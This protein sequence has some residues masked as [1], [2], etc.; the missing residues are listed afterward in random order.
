[1]GNKGKATTTSSVSSMEM[2]LSVGI[3][4]EIADS[5][6]FTVPRARRACVSNERIPGVISLNSFLFIFRNF[7]TAEELLD[8]LIE[9]FEIPDPRFSDA[10]SRPLRSV[11][12]SYAVRVL[13]KFRTAN[14]R[15]MQFRVVNF[16]SKWIN[17]AHYFK[18][19]FASK[20]LELAQQ[21]TMFEWRMYRV[22]SSPTMTL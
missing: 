11:D 12:S 14:K 21:I 18:M 2:G 16:V 10:E 22:P 15:K 3:S 13:K 19:D 1:M 4:Y 17:D 6:Y 7:T 5:D 8:I 20:P 9:R